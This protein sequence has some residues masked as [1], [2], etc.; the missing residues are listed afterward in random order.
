MQVLINFGDIDSSQALSDHVQQHVDKALEHVARHVT[1]V[2]VHLRD[3]KQKGQAADDRRCTMEGR[4]A[5]HQPIAVEARAD[6]IYKAVGECAN[7]LG[8]A[9]SHKLE[10][11]QR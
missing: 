6:D 7:K 4:I 3:D 9:V 1:R 10:R 11:L 2:E 8:R 5:N